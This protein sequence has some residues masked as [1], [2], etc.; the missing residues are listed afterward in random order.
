MWALCW[1]IAG[2]MQAVTFVGVAV[3]TGGGFCFV[4]PFEECG[5]R[6]AGLD[7]VRFRGPLTR[8]LKG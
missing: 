3:C 6:A 5:I 8:G 4:D 7:A 2:I 1:N